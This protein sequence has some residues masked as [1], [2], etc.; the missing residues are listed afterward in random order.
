LSNGVPPIVAYS[1]HIYNTFVVDLG[2]S[3][4][5]KSHEINSIV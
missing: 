5:K 3:E 4:K 2:C 1:R